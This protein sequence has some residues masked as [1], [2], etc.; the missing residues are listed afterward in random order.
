MILST[1]LSQH[2]HEI[3]TFK[4]KLSGK[5]FPARLTR[6]SLGKFCIWLYGQTRLPDICSGLTA[7]QRWVLRR[8]L[9]FPVARQ[10]I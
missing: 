10:R 3:S 4:N 8:A 5:D 6:S 9:S 7:G 1:D 2:F